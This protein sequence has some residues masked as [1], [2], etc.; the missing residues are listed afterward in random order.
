MSRSSAMSDEACISSA[1]MSGVSSDISGAMSSA[2]DMSASCGALAPMSA[3]TPMSIPEGGRGSEGAVAAAA[4]ITPSGTL[5]RIMTPVFLSMINASGWSARARSR[6]VG[7]S[8]KRTMWCSPVSRLVSTTPAKVAWRAIAHAPLLP[9][10]TSR[11]VGSSGVSA[12][13]S[14]AVGGTARSE[15]IDP[16]SRMLTPSSLKTSARLPSLVHSTRRTLKPT[17]T[18]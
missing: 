9:S 17:A 12:L 2:S 6:S 18:W 1:R 14:T 8:G 16:T 7:I 5:A 15:S 13:G 11:S 3:S 10:W 4:A